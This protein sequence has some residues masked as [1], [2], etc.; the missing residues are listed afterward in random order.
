MSAQHR[1]GSILLAVLLVG[2]L[3]APAMVGTAAADSGDSLESAVCED[4]AVVGTP[5]WVLQTTCGVMDTETVNESLATEDK[6]IALYT[7]ATGLSDRWDSYSTTQGNYLNDTETIA[8]LEAKHAI[9]QA[10]EAGDGSTTAETKGLAAVEDYYATKQVNLLEE[11]SSQQAQAAYM[12]NVSNNDTNIPSSW[13]YPVMSAS[14]SDG[15]A[16]EN[17]KL[18]GETVNKTISLVNGTEYTYQVAEAQAKLHIWSSS[19]DAE[20]SDTIQ[21]ALGI[22]ETY[23]QQDSRYKIGTYDLSGITFDGSLY[24]RG[25]FRV[26]GVSDSTVYSDTDFYNHRDWQLRWQE[27]EEQSNRVVSNYDGNF[28]T[29]VYDDLNSGELNVSELYG[30][31]GMARYLSGDSNVTSDRF[32]MAT[33]SIL[34]M[35]RPD[36]LGSSFVIEYDAATDKTTT[37]NSS[38]DSYETTYGWSQGTAEGLLFSEE[39][40]ADGFT[41][42][43]TYNASALNGTQMVA[44]ATSDETVKFYKGNFTITKMYDS[45]GNAVNSTEW[46]QPKYATYNASEYQKLLEDA[47]EDRAEIQAALEDESGIGFP[48]SGSGNT[49]LVLIA[50]AVVVAL[51]ALKNRST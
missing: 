24:T 47:K 30:A 13:V 34:G 38:A 17:Q 25:Q 4:G 7:Q 41:V 20:G 45:E 43:E 40:P 51:F 42:N 31:E 44:S 32:E 15:A 26:A 27:I 12:A 39:V 18:T 49:G 50:A 46:Q 16:A 3:V 5:L 6:Q 33:Y 2:S 1:I 22:D 37:F 11:L 48:L 36:N 35:D 8:S 23:N 19:S 9:G 10:Y 21:F 28:T 29:E 14:S